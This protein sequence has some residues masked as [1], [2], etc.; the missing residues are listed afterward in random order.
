VIFG[1]TVTTEFAFYYPGKTRNP[2][3]LERTPGGS[4]SG[5]AA[6]V[7]A[8]MLPLSIGTQTNGSI[9]R[10]AA[11][12]GV[13]GMKPSH[14]LVS[15]EGVL[16]HSRTLDHVGPFARS[17]DDIGLILDIMAGYDE[18]DPDTRPYAV[19][20]FAGGA[21]QKP[22]VTPR[23]AYVRTP[24]WGKAEKERPKRSRSLPSR[25]VRSCSASSCTSRFTAMHGMTFAP[26]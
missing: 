6:A 8:G 11:Y 16:S 18:A 19:P 7:A 17:L 2:H 23:I 1:K 12:C 14:G 3:D 20:D 22:P 26:S 25:S 15:R 10:P 5:S 21:R 13:F 9:I 24:A 4:S